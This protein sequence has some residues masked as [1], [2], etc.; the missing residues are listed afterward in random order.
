MRR[1]RNLLLLLSALAGINSPIFAADNVVL[2][3]VWPA[4][5]DAPSFTAVGEY[6][7]GKPSGENLSALRTQ[8]DARA[9]YYWLVRTR[10]KTATFGAQ[11]T[12]EVRR[13]T[14][15]AVE[16]RTFPVD[17]PSGSHAFN[18]GLTGSDWSDPTER[19][20]A[21]R[22]TLTDANGSPLAAEQSFLW[23][24]SAP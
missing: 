9:G 10:A 15:Q 17:L 19:P 13:A 24:D 21:W 22:L 16:T 18:A 11:L 23:Q 5:R 3:R 4:Y 14:A 8:P 1:A 20:V 12:L 2:T 6:F 7:G